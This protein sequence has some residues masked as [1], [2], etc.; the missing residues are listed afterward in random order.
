MTFEVLAIL[1]AIEVG[2]ISTI[3]ALDWRANRRLDAQL[4]R[5]IA[6]RVR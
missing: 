5:A 6:R 2:M 3:V 1:C 4:P